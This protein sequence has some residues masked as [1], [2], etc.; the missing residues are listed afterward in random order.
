MRVTRAVVSLALGTALIAS[1]VGCSQDNKAAS[2]QHG[3][4]SV[5]ASTNVWGSVASAVAGDHTS[6]TSIVSSPA[7]DPH[8]FEVTPSDAAAIA[9]AA[10]VVYNGGGYDQWVDDVL[11]G[12]QGVAAVDAY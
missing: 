5:V 11:S 12:H 8:S 3:T 4:A 7:Q 6:V 2:D 9:D 10:L 1:A